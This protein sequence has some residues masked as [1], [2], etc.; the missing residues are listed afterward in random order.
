MFTTAA[1]SVRPHE[2]PST[3]PWHMHRYHCQFYG[4]PTNVQK[5][6]RWVG[7]RQKVSTLPWEDCNGVRQALISANNNL[8]NSSLWAK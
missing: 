8:P 2:P 3:A 1:V 4:T 5:N 6:S 7:A